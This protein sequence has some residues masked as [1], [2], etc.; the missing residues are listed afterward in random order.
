MRAH[1]TRAGGDLRISG[2][3]HAAFARRDRLAGVETEHAGVR[4]PRTDQ[5]TISARRQS[6]RSIL[7]D[8]EAVMTS[9]GQH[10]GHVTGKA[11]EVDRDDRLAT[12]RQTALGMIK[13]DATGA[14]LDI[15]QHDLRAEITYDGCGRRE[16]QCGHDN[17]VARTDSACLRG[18]MESRRRRVY[19]DSLDISAHECSEL[20][21]ELACFGPGREPPRSQHGYRCS[22]FLLADGRLEA[23][24]AGRSSTWLRRQDLRRISRAIP[25]TGCCRQVLEPKIS[26]E[27]S[28]RVF[29]RKLDA[30][31][32]RGIAVSGMARGTSMS[33]GTDSNLG[34]RSV[35]GI[36]G[37]DPIKVHQVVFP[38]CDLEAAEARR[39]VLLQI[40]DVAVCRQRI[41][42]D[43]V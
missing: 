13:I 3:E 1:H 18:K 5:T 30:T 38:S 32:R 22:D 42:A 8:L 21:F 23:W 12:R 27:L 24:D 19:G 28:P 36:G 7:N 29:S 34:G 10:L 31:L 11:A 40:E 43:L 6:M 25:Q 35:R 14:L 2:H 39:S 15:D 9:K 16:G 26:H 41:V 33:T 4:F 17:F 37:D 20:L